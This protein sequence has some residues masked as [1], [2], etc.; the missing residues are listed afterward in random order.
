MSVLF[1]NVYIK[2]NWRE[3]TINLLKDVPHSD[4]YVNVTI[5]WFDLYKLVSSLLF[6][7]KHPKV[8]KIFVTINSAKLAEV[9]GFV[10]LKERVS[11]EHYKAL[12]YMHSK[13]VSKPGNANIKD[14]VELMRFFIVD[15]YDL[16]M[17][18]FSK[19]FDLYGVNLGVYN[20]NSEKYGPYRFSSFHYSGNFVTINLNTLRETYDRTNVDM[21]YF[22][23]EAFWGKLT[24]VEKAFNA[25]DSSL[26]ISNHYNER[27]PSS[28]Y[29]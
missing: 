5:D 24:S 18:V 19:G 16:T 22:G 1:Y 7:R 3:V 9:R 17:E 28:F 10:K 12:T 8:K 26:L 13:G 20:V 21:D 27:Y 15:R 4:I 11:L 25:H 14:W 29:R 6:F 2:N 23:V